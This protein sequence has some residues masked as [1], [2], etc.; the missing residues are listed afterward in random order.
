MS[1]ITWMSERPAPSSWW[2]FVYFKKKLHGYA[3]VRSL[4]SSLEHHS[5]PKSRIIAVPPALS[6]FP[7]STDAEATGL[8]RLAHKMGWQRLIITSPPIHQFRA[9]ISTISAAK[10]ESL[11]L[12][13]YNSVGLPPKWCE[14]TVHSQGIEKGLRK[15]LLRSGEWLRLIRYHA[16]GDLIS[17]D[18]AI[19]YLNLRDS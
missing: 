12:K 9:F 8:V 15:D 14:D 13:I 11:K 16:K 6:D 17:A 3:G 10:R 18:E 4:R 5:I 19:E 1:L 7:P 2:S